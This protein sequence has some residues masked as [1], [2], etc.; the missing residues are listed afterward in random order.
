MTFRDTNVRLNENI[1]LGPSDVGVQ[2][3]EQTREVTASSDPI[4]RYLIEATRTPL[5]SVEEERRL[6]VRMARRRASFL[7]AACGIP[8][9]WIPAARL[10]RQVL[11]GEKPALKVFMIGGISEK[12]F[13]KH[14]SKAADSVTRLEEIAGEMTRM[15]CSIHD[16]FAL[17]KLWREGR[18]LCAS[19]T[20]RLPTLLRLVKEA[21]RAVRQKARINRRGRRV[22][23]ANCSS[24]VREAFLIH[25]AF[26]ETRNQLVSANLRLVVFIARQVARHPSQLL[27][28]IQEG[29][30]GLLYATEK[31]DARE[32]CQFHSYAYWWIRQSMTRAVAN[33]SRLIRQPVNLQDAPVKVREAIAAYRAENGRDPT[34]EELGK[35]LD[36]PRGEAERVF[37][38]PVRT[39][40]LDQTANGEDDSP[41]ADLLADPHATES[42]ADAKWVLEGLDKVLHTLAPREREV[43]LLRFGLGHDQTYTL[44]DVAK[45]YNLSRERVR[46]IEI[47][48]LEKLRQ[49]ERALQLK[50][51][52]DA[53]T[54]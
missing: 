8:S 31:Y 34:P 10:A 1:D 11:K 32:R 43:L 13:H 45:I 39:F 9:L 40:S 16:Q 53:V 18:D 52:M 44:E 54:D 28:L 5:L 24:R 7:T 20:F 22:P 49:P 21:D 29:N 27:E 6:A 33:K 25:K 50:A 36:L 3:V 42:P 23:C 47:R 30:F 51:L 14:L 17:K 46:Q 35:I 2:T 15:G 37:R 4:R 12:K 41:L 38:T 26:V 19:L 48:A